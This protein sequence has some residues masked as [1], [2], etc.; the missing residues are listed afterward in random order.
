MGSKGLQVGIPEK[1]LQT[2]EEDL[3]KEQDQ[4][5][6]P[7]YEENPEVSNCHLIVYSTRL[8]PMPLGLVFV[9][10]TYSVVEVS[11]KHF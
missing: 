9:L 11:S 4:W 3:A 7:C 5:K 10:Y 1:M 2:L 8:V 6:A